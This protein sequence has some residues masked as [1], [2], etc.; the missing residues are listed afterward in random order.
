MRGINKLILV[1]NVGRD[2]DIR[3]MNSGKKVAS[4]SVATSETW[5]DKATGE[6]K[7]RTNWHQIVVFN[8]TLVG[9]VEKYVRKGS[10]LYV[11]GQSQSRKYTD[12]DGADRHIT[13]CVISDFRG[14]IQLLDKSEGR[15][16]AEPEDYGT[17]KTLEQSYKETV[18]ASEYKTASVHDGSLDED[19]A[20]EIGF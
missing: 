5:K 8:E 9:I 16:S 15:P 20:D 17:V 18:G 4:F 1:G 7:E 3:A 12:K 19:L 11:E 10:R 2:P 14:D 13:E 6:R